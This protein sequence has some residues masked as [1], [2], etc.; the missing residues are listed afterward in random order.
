MNTIDTEV[1]VIGSG[2]GAAACALR[3]SIAGLRVLIIEKG[4]DV[5]PERDFH[6]TQDP[7]YL[8]KYL[9]GESSDSI[10]YTY[11]EALGG[12]SGF[13]EMVSLRAP[14]K[15]FA[16]RDTR[17]RRLWPRQIDRATLDRYYDRAEEMLNVEQIGEDEIPKSGIA[18]A[19]MMKNLGYSCDRARYAVNGCI[20]SGFCISGC[21]FG[22]KQSLHLNY[23]P[24]ARDAGA[25]VMTGIE[26]IDIRL[27]EHDVRRT[28]YDDDIDVISHRYVVACRKGDERINIRAKIVVLGGGTIGTAKLLLRSQ[29]HLSRLSTHVGRNIAINGSVKAV[30]MLPEGFIEGD[31]V[32]GRTHPGMISYEFFDERGI[33]VSSIKPM[34]ITVVGTTHVSVDRGR[35]HAGYWG[36]AHVEIMKNY[37]RR[38]IV[39]YA[40]G[41]TAPTAGI[42]R[43]AN[44]EFEPYLDIDD[45]LRRYYH[46][47]KELLESIFT[48]NGAEVLR[49]KPID[50]EGTEAEA[51]NFGTTHMIGSC[52]MAESKEHGVVD[53]YG[54]VFDYPGLFVADGAAVPSSLAVNSSLTILA[55]AER[56]ADAMCARF[57]RAAR[58]HSLT[59][60]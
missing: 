41:L 50:G 30:G 43:L 49:A 58:A 51:I 11:G 3:L 60:Q 8:L 34:P 57:G 10:A 7:N 18:F 52:R 14:S 21:L 31:M 42:R 59:G 45:E 13:Y 17:G 26:A 24:Q 15:V 22:G 56:I 20:G 55:N 27:R 9:K 35:D 33:T 23:L 37:R 38:M 2:F 19:T 54:E 29:T 4:P 39:L 12:G 5:V 16:Q 32:S 47:T 40:L 1:L 46:E 48:R 44:G 6:Q 28:M 25:R 53:A 36:S